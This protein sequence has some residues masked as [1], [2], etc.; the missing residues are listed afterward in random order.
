MIVGIS[1]KA[2]SG[3]DQFAEYLQEIFDK[4]HHR[5]FAKM[6]FADELKMM[7]MTSF[8]L[9]H[10]QLWGDLKEIPDKR[11]RKPVVNENAKPDEFYWTGREIMQAIGSFYRSIDYD[12]WVKQIDKS[13][14]KTPEHT[15]FMITD[16]RHINECNYVK[17]NGILVRV[18][19]A[20]EERKIHGMDHESETALDDREQGYFDIEINNNGT[21]EELKMAADDAAKAILMLEDM[22]QGRSYNG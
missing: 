14:K 9:D 17:Q 10:D 5:Y 12:F 6:A 22:K 4:K 19:R 3:K 15:D 16:V 1:G 21:L 18:R 20:A 7:C 11:Y 2:R 8:G 13:I